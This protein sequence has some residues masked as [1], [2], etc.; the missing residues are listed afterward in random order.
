MRGIAMA[1]V[2]V[3]LVI[4]SGREIREGTVSIGHGFI[5]LGWLAATCV[6]IAGGW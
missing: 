5:C 4:P 2:L 1:I 6:V 3:A